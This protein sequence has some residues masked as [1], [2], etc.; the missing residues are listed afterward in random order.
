[1]ATVTPITA[2]TGEDMLQNLQ[3]IQPSKPLEKSIKTMDFPSKELISMSLC[4]LKELNAN[5]QEVYDI[6]QF[7]G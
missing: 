4:G 2:N 1:V 5:K 3:N 7:K 6:S